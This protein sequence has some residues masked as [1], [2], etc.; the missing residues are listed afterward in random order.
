MRDVSSDILRRIQAGDRSAWEDLYGRFR[1]RLLCSIRLRL[2][3]ELRRHL[4]S[5]DV[6]QSVVREAFDDLGH[7]EAR[8][9]GS[10]AGY[11]QVCVLNKLRKMA[12]RLGAQKR[13]GGRALTESME[14]RAPAPAPQE[15]RYLDAERF[16]RLERGLRALDEGPRE[17]VLLRLVEGLTN[18][19]VAARLGI[20]EDQSSKSYNRALARLAVSSADRGATS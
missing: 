6:L 20:S 15:L 2:G 8:G 7:V 13:A 12:E 18:A 17:I 5:E 14:E 9:P 1:D 19:E 4:E 11:L 3:P 10:L 16:D